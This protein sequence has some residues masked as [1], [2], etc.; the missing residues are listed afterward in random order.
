MN[1]ISLCLWGG[2]FAMPK[3]HQPAFVLRL[4]VWDLDFGY[5]ALL[6]SGLGNV[7]CPTNEAI[8]GDIRN[9][10]AV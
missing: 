2:E 7:C 3:Q 9:K 1:V 8:P 10:I 4:C 6:E 5:S